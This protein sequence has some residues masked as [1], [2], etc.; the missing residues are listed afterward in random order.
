[1]IIIFKNTDGN[2]NYSELI[3][4][5]MNLFLTYISPTNYPIALWGNLHEF[6]LFFWEIKKNK[7]QK[8]APCPSQNDSV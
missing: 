8:N 4:I 6:T 3:A 7:K 5:M 1:M 2:L